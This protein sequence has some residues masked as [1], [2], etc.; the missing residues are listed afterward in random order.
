MS[1]VNH[2][3]AHPLEQRVTVPTGGSPPSPTLLKSMR[4]LNLHPIHL[5][6]LTETYGPVMGVQ[7][8]AASG[9]S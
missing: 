5:Y 4:E 6:G 1:I 9:T 2:E 7:L 8:A 3:K